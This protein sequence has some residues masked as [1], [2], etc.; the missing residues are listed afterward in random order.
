VGVAELIC[1]TIRQ[2]TILHSG[3][4]PGYVTVSVGCATMVPASRRHS[5]VLVQKADDALYTAKRAGRNR[6]VNS[7]HHQSE[8]KAVQAG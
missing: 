1:D 7:N 5:A 8:K 2:L 4:P 6:V 3:N